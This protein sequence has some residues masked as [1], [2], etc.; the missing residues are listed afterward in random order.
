MRVRFLIPS[1]VAAGF[2]PADS[3]SAALEAKSAEPPDTPTLPLIEQL[4]LDHRYNL[5]AHRSHGSHGSHG[6]HSSHRSSSSEGS[7]TTTIPQVVVPDT[8]SSRNTESVP[9]SS[10]LPSSPSIAP[11][12][13]G[14]T[15][16]FKEILMQV[17][18][19]LNVYGYYTGAIDGVMGP[20]TQAAISKFQSAWGLPVTG[21][22]TPEV[23]NAL[24]IVA[25]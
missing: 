5:A 7:G 25:Q 16:K 20:Q 13:P 24:G 9:E 8:G 21:T 15:A 3:A 14:N 22:L 2:A 10:V 1:L 4:R 19:G 12:L 18:L 17:Q 23:L 6:S 11:V